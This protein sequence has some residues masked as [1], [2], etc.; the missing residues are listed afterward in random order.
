[1]KNEKRIYAGR[2]TSHFA[3]A[4]GNVSYI[5]RNFILDQFPDNFFKKVT[6]DTTLSAN[7]MDK[8]RDNV[9]SKEGYPKLIIRPR[10]VFDENTMFARLP[11]WIHTTY[12]KWKNLSGNYKPV[13]LDVEKDIYLY[14][15]FDRIKINFEIEIVCNTKISQLNIAQYLKSTVLHKGYFYVHSILEKQVPKAFI[16]T[17]HDIRHFDNSTEDG[18]AQFT[19]YLETGS[20]HFI[21]EKIN[22]QCGR[23]DYYFMYGTNL[24][25]LFEDF[26]QMDDGEQKDQSNTNFRIQDPFIVEFWSP[27]TFFMEALT[28]LD[29]RE[30]ELGWDIN[31]LGDKVNLVY[32]MQ[33]VP[34]G[35]YEDPVTKI[36]YSFYK[37]QAYVTDDYSANPDI[38]YDTIELKKFFNH[39]L[40]KVIKYCLEFHIDLDELIKFRLYNDRTKLCN[41]DVIEMDWHTLTMKQHDYRPNEMYHL[42]VY[43]NPK[44]YNQILKRI[45]HK[46]E[47]N[48]VD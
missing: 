19:D 34:E 29:P 47:K 41:P 8:D 18:H 3:T 37:K 10:I 12:F 26:P 30:T 38:D 4:I 35:I 15:C 31:D 2:A 5:V 16:E 28:D 9:Y 33:M 25:C 13:F 24:L 23:P 22:P 6:I 48:F 43:V 11:D 42:Y 44:E 20:Q 32:T 40:K 45:M 17:I 27:N 7:D 21:T 14:T 46:E 36:K 1:M 39:N